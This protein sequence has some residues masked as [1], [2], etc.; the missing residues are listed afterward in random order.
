MSWLADM[1]PHTVTWAAV[2]GLNSSGDRTYGA[3]VQLAARVQ[4]AS[5]LTRDV[6]GEEVVITHRVALT[7]AVAQHDR[8]TLPDGSVRTVRSLAR[9]QEMDGDQELIIAE[10]S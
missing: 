9:A 6:D 5:G 7:R 8:L 3:G 4:Y 1:M 10:V 2:S